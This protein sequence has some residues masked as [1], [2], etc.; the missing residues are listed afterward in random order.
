MGVLGYVE[1][2]LEVR[3]AGHSH[4]GEEGERAGDV[5]RA[6]PVFGS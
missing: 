4:S 2:E 5:E 1:G 6:D 3:G